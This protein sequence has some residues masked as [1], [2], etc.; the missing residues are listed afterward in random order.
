MSIHIFLL[1]Y[2]EELMLPHTIRHYR[3]NF[4][5]ASITIFDN[6]STDRSAAIAEEAGCRVIKYDSNEQQDE[7]LLIWVRS[8]MWKDFVGDGGWVIMCDMDEWLNA[9][10]EELREEQKKG[11][12]VLTTQGINMV[13]ESKCIDHSDIDLFAIQKGYKSDHMSKKV[14][15]LYPLVSMEYWFGAHKAFPQG[16]VVYSE[17]TYLLKH[18]DQL[19]EEYLVEKHRKRWERNVKSRAIGMNQ[20]YF[21]ERDKTVEVYQQA[22]AN[23][24]IIL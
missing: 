2:N 17:K 4:P 18:Y 19:G 7:Q 8:H 22:L 16:H 23:A 20:H 15:F 13:G 11:V 6:H 5:S 9:T 10:E 12:T 14:C 21:I 3:K 1:C 24:Q